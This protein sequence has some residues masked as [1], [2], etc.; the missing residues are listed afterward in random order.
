MS[1]RGGRGQFVLQIILPQ[2]AQ[3]AA[4]LKHSRGDTPHTSTQ[5]PASYFHP[6]QPIPNP[7]PL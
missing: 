3:A 6:F 7:A 4:A 5:L 1:L 2:C